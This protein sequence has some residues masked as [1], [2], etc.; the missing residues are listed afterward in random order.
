MSP[1][2]VRPDVIVVGAGVIGICA[3]LRLA[4]R[5]L[6]V[7]IWARELPEHTTSAV[8]GAIWYPYL[9]E[10]RERVAQWGARTFAQLAEFAARRDAAVRMVDVVEVFVEEPDL[11]WADG[12]EVTRLAG[13]EVPDPFAMAVRAR[14]PVCEVPRHLRFL[15]AELQRAGVPIERRAIAS[16]D[17]AFATAGVVVNCTGLGARDLCADDSVRP[18]RGQVAFVAGATVPHAWIDDTSARPRYVIPRPDGVVVGGT[19]QHGDERLDVDDAERAEML[20]AAG[21]VFPAIARAADADVTARVGLRP[22]RPTVCLEA[23]HLSGGRLLVHD[24]GHGGSGWTL[25][26]GCADEV[27]RLVAG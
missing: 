22:Y 10:P 27:A 25:A 18:V 6:R 8:A 5:G 21:S 24:Y 12:V 7:R 4:Q 13:S 26:W 3:A 23:E 17:E 1:A 19:S 11:W 16:F 14:V 15:R 9:A 20:A 2:A